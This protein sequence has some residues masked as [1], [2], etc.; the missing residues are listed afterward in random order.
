MQQQIPSNIMAG[1]SVQGKCNGP[2]MVILRARTRQGHCL[3]HHQ[4]PSSI[5]VDGPCES[6]RIFP[7]SKGLPGDQHPVTWGVLR[8]CPLRRTGHIVSAPGSLPS[9]DSYPKCVR[10][11]R[12]LLQ[13]QSTGPTPRISFSRSR[14]GPVNVHLS[15]IPGNAY[16][17][18]LWNLL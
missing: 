14:F 3:L 9:T 15:Q 2:L 17:T 8:G 18:P 12:G 1:G 11:T 7:K 16:V 4:V 13:T 5:V 6:Q 10:I